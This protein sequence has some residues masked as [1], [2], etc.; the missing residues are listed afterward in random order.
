MSE[1]LVWLIGH[2]TWHNP[3]FYLD[4]LCGALLGSRISAWIEERMRSAGY[5]TNFCEMTSCK[6][7]LL[8]KI[9]IDVF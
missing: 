4:R 1:R 8:A 3:L 5:V 7:R 9:L 6:N 2:F